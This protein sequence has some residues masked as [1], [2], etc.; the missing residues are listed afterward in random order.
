MENQSD[1]QNHLV[2]IQADDHDLLVNSNNENV[3]IYVRIWNPREINLKIENKEIKAD[4]EPPRGIMWL[5][6]RVKQRREF[7]DDEIRSVKKLI[8]KIKER[9]PGILMLALDMIVVF[10]RKG[11]VRLCKRSGKWSY[12]Q[13][14]T[15]MGAYEVDETQSSAV[16]RDKDARIKKKSNGLVTSEKFKD[17]VGGFLHGL[18]NKVVLDDGVAALAVATAALAVAAEVLLAAMKPVQSMLPSMTSVK[19]YDNPASR[20]ESYRPAAHSELFES[21]LP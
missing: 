10:V 2:E 17:S 16:V 4:K 14:V 18:M 20:C 6:E 8:D 1:V 15:P 21:Q 19:R 12:I 5:K 11:R 13:E 9:E 7:T 3:M